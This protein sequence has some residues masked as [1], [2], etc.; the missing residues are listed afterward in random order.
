MLATIE[1]VDREGRGGVIQNLLVSKES[2]YIQHFT[3]IFE[4]LWNQGVDAIERIKDM[5]AGVDFD[6]EVIQSSLRIQKIYLNTI[7]SAQNEILLILPTAN[8]VTR[9]EKLG[10]IRLTINAVK[11]RNVKVRILMP[12][13]ESIQ[14]VSQKLTVA[15]GK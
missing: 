7:K 14:H 1:K 13:H 12:A 8:A 5:E 4:G 10:V 9:E 2:P 11:E 15:E 3:S 6:I